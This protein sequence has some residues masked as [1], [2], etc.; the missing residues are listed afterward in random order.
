M[1]TNNVKRKQENLRRRKKTL[2][3]KV[4]KFEKD[5]DFEVVLILSKKGCYFTFRLLDQD[6]WPLSIE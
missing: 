6:T 5:F 4:Y 3:K 1:A 2:V